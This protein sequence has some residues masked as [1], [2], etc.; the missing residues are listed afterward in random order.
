MD[1]N[2]LPGLLGT[3]RTLAGAR[4]L[5]VEGPVDPTKLPGLLGT[6][7]TLAGARGLLGLL[8]VKLVELSVRVLLWLLCLLCVVGASWS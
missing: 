7:R 2:K 4:G 8:L 3:V 1:P 6:V 5:L